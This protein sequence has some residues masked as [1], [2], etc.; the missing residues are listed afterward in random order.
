MTVATKEDRLFAAT[1]VAHE[2]VIC[3]ALRLPDGRIIRGHRHSHCLHAAKNL[4]DWQ[5]DPQ[6][7]VNGPPWDSA[8]MSHD[9][10]FMTSK[11]RFVNREEGLRLQLAAGIP[12]A[13]PS[14][15]REAYLFSEDLY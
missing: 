13:C 6:S 12:S 14:G 7:G 9:Q 11:N 3:S 8:T 10:G 15:Y 5:N 4:I 2:I 1:V